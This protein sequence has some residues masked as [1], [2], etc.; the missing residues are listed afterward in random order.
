MP[1]RLGGFLVR[2]LPGRFRCFAMLD[3]S[4]GF[5][6]F[7]VHGL[8][9]FVVLSSPARGRGYLVVLRPP[10][11]I[12]GSMPGRLLG[13]RLPV[14]RFVADGFSIGRCT[15]LRIPGGRLV[16]TARSFVVWSTLAMV[17]RMS[18]GL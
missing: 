8:S 7:A 13:C 15:V 5:S 4:G 16:R 14:S 2:F 18:G 6:G 3:L 11:M 17:L 1:G 10:G 12:G 9:G